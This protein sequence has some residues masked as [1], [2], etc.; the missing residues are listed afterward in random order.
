MILKKFGTN[1]KII[2]V[3]MLIHFE[4]VEKS[5]VNKD[6]K[7]YDF[8]YH[9]TLSFSK[10][11]LYFLEMAALLQ[12]N[13]FVIPYSKEDVEKAINTTINLENVVFLNISWN[14]GLKEVLINCKV[15]L[16]PSLW[17]APVEGALLKS[18]YYN[19]CVA[20][21]PAE[22]SFQEELPKTVVQK[23][24]LDINETSIIL[25]S[26]INSTKLRE[27]FKKESKKWLEI[28]VAEVND[29]FNNFIENEFF[30]N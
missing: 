16:N 24:S 8:L 5:A 23:L 9:N 2:K 15:V 22:L 13:S 26:L 21:F 7:E 20:V 25:Q 28:Y 30:L 4:D 1:S 6:Q 12:N 18:L 14:S 19:G 17:S 10:G 29:S 11:L 3:G 27:E